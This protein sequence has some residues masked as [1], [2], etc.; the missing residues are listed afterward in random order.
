MIT[1]GISILFFANFLRAIALIVFADDICMSSYSL[2]LSSFK[3]RK[4]NFLYLLVMLK[5]RF[6]FH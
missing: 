5:F 2:K 6:F 1:L 3:K 4:I